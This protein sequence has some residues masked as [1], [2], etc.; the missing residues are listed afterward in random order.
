[1]ASS[2]PQHLGLQQGWDKRKRH[3]TMDTLEFSTFS[4]RTGLPSFDYANFAACTFPVTF[5]DKD[6]D[7][8]R[9]MKTFKALSDVDGKIQ[10][11]YDAAFYHGAPVSLQLAGR[12]L[13]EEK[14]LEMVEVVADLLQSNKQVDHTDCCDHC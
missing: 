9:N 10:A 1:M 7:K 13:E 3:C 8:S 4:V 5:A 6:L 14:V 12:R 11:D 2:W